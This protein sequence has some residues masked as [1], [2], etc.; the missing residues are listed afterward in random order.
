MWEVSWRLNRT[1]KYWPS[2]LWLSQPFFPVLLGC[3]NGIFLQLLWTYCSRGYIIIW[4]PPTSCECYNFALNSTPRQSR[5][6]PP[7]SSDIVDRM[8]LLFTQVHFFFWQLGRFGGQYATLFHNYYYHNY[9]TFSRVFSHYHQLIVFPLSFS[10]PLEFL[11]PNSSTSFTNPLASV[12]SAPLSI[13][14]IF[15]FVFHSFSVL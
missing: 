9:F 14:I 11:F 13:A 15:T 8:H 2:L 10:C 5:S 1:A 4:H 3:S 12:L 7:W 6:P